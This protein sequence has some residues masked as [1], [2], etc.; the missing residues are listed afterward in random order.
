MP[1][2]RNLLG[3]SVS[4]ALAA[5]TVV[6]GESSQGGDDPKEPAFAFDAIDTHIHTSHAQAAGVKP[7]PGEMKEL[8]DAD[9]TALVTRLKDEMKRGRISGALA[10]GQLG[11]GA[12]DPL[13]IAGS[14]AVAEAIPDVRVVGAIDPTRI[15]A[16]HLSAVERQIERHRA[17]LVAFKA[18]LGYMHYGPEHENY[19]PYYRLAAKHRLPVIFHTGDTW[20]T[21]AKLKYAHP[22]RV[23]EAAVDF[24]EVRMVMAHFG[25]PWSIDAAEVIYKNENVWA[26]LSAFLVGDEKV[27]EGVL[28]SVKTKDEVFLLMTADLRRAFAY[29][30]RYDRFLRKRLAAGPDGELPPVHRGPHSRNAS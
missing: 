28:K 23:D 13:G 11:G 12:D 17:K 18:Y 5:G 4:A 10:M 6:T 3:F 8:L 26:D 22:L 27:F 1:T 25:Y 2:R 19:A 24:P 7:L 15:D 21:K 16:T 29:T 20:S 9:P 14:I 30:E